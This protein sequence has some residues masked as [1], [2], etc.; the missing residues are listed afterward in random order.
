MVR[1]HTVCGAHFDNPSIKHWFFVDGLIC[2]GRWPFYM[3]CFRYGGVFWCRNGV[4][5]CKDGNSSA[6]VRIGILSVRYKEVTFRRLVSFCHI[7]HSLILCLF[8]SVCANI[9]QYSQ[10][11]KKST[12][13][14]C[15]YWICMAQKITIFINCVINCINLWNSIFPLFT[16]LDNQYV[17]I[18]ARYANESCT[19]HTI[20]KTTPPLQFRGCFVYMLFVQ[21][22]F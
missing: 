21:I 5:L 1:R 19:Q 9:Q 13:F 22:C 16:V 17:P 15:L 10:F 7:T 12:L 6:C 11:Q 2:W 20:N 4:G 18:C 14:L 3:W 8:W